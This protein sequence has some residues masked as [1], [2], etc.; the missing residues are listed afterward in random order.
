MLCPSCGGE[1]PDGFRWCG[2]CG[3]ALVAV[4]VDDSRKVVTLVF[5]DV[6]GSTALGERFDPEVVRSVMS[7]FFDAAREVLDRHGGTVEKFIGD[8]VMAAFGIPLV[9][10]D[11]ALRGV[12]A[13]C[14]LRDRLRVFADEVEARYGV[15]VGVRIGV[16]TGE[17]VAGDAAAGQAFASGD[18]VNVAARLEQ[19][20]APGEVLMG[21]STLALVRDAVTVDPVAPLS[22]KGKADA[23]SAWQLVD[24]AADGPGVAR[25]FDAP[26]IGRKHEL[27]TLLDAW[28]QAHELRAPR[29]VTVVATAGTG[30][31]RL[32]GELATRAE[33]SG[34]VLVGRCLA[35]G[36]GIT[37]WPVAEGIRQAAGID[38]GD[39][40]DEANAKLAAL[41]GTADDASELRGALGP[42]LGLGGQGHALEETFWAVRTLFES[43]AARRPLVLV[44]DDVHWAEPTLLDL[45]D[46]LAGS[47]A[48][49]P[50]LVVCATRPEL[51]ERR[52]EL[53]AG[54]SS[55]AL[56]M[57]APLAAESASELLTWQLHH[58]ALPEAIRD[59]VL[60][61]ADGNPL[62]VQ[63]LSR[64]LIDDGLIV[65]DN[66]AWRV[67]A[68][69][70]DLRMPAT[71]Q[72]LLAARLDQ[73][74]QSD[75]DVAQR[76]S[77]VGHVFWPGA[78]RE[79]AN[80]PALV[81]PGLRTLERKQLIV[82]EPSSLA[83][84]DAFRF[85]H[86]LVRDAA[87]A[88][89]A[90]RTRADLHERFARWLEHT[91]GERASELAAVLGYHLEQSAAYHTEL[92]ATAD[93]ERVAREASTRLGEG[94][95][96]ALSAG[97]LPAA[98]NLLGR[99]ADVL[100]QGDPERLVLRFEAIPALAETGRF[101]EANQAIDELI[102]HGGEGR[103][104][105][106]ASAWRA[107]LTVQNDGLGID[108][109]KHTAERWRAACDAADDH[110]GQATA[111][112]FLAKMA[113]WS[114]RA[115]TAEGIWERAAEH[116]ALAGDAREE[117]ESLVWMLIAAM[118][119]PTPV[120]AAI[121][122]CEAIAGRVG[123]SRK[124]RVMA[125][126]E[127]GVLEAMR[128]NASVGRELVA[129]G[130]AELDEL[131]LAFMA[132][133]LG[134]E[135]AVVEQMAGDPAGA[136][137]VL[138]PSIERLGELGSA[139]FQMTA[140]CMCTHALCML[141][142]I[143]E[144]KSMLTLTPIEFDDGDDFGIG[145]AARGM[146]AA[147]DGDDLE[148]MRLVED[149]VRRASVTDFLW[150]HGD[151]LA[152]LAHVHAAAGRID[153][154]LAALDDADA[155][156]AAKGAT[157]AL[158]VTAARRVELSTRN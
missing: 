64:M 65:R 153:Q 74:E 47:T 128:G 120:E 113:F 67:T 81:G 12:R 75:R 118:F 16:N 89:L 41:V 18:A 66:G 17:V 60:A 30:K 49:V 104:A 61:S 68:H 146:I 10:E 149:A 39:S 83:A 154:A 156:Y 115:A 91:R 131:G 38:D 8:A 148:A 112:G 19:A 123:A 150:H 46:Y 96:R 147:A 24:V 55:G 108:E 73:L 11:D 119:G 31:T 88:G 42:V 37:F 132:A 95:R 84:E 100:A 6:S 111:L 133:V 63:E 102:A 137:S 114:S 48:S 52:P 77:V 155:R 126:V 76:A 9:R 78:V 122:R 93:A 58:A 125:S 158:A 36:E 116:A 4:P 129:R 43:L 105:L 138:R 29:R 26:L 54:R 51:L 152:D 121:E 145:I 23:V 71:I 130:R 99:A 135:A 27:Q 80:E 59:R 151:R 50:L 20:A 98:A 33:A 69:L 62:F 86:I 34:Q 103:L 142:E 157:A 87:Y 140:A 117:A 85:G 92:G 82:A 15:R 134:Q 124:V 5:A 1:N 57:L 109:C 40:A 127:R 44:F 3:G 28:Q 90:K 139:G 56:L 14:E 141:G 13:A 53:A 32:I 7:G 110:A 143:D 144:A 79:L 35:Y 107:F 21:E 97:D 70:H 94:G 45:I 25:R 106:A 2:Y 22:L 72:A 136:V 101:D